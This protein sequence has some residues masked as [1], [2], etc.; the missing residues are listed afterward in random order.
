[1]YMYPSSMSLHVPVE[2]VRR[3]VR[4]CA[5]TSASV[6]MTM[7]DTGPLGIELSPIPVPIALISVW[8][9]AFF[10]IWCSP[11]FSTLGSFP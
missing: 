7:R 5:R 6:M 8:I 4:I 9:S 1:M 11:A 10:R 3:R 2:N